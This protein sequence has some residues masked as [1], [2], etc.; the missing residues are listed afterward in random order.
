MVCGR[1]DFGDHVMGIY[2]RRKNPFLI[3]KYIDSNG[4]FPIA[5]VEFLAGEGGPP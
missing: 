5:M 2:I 3:G 4:G 1:L